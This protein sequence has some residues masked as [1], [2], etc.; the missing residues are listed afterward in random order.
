MEDKTREQY[1]DDSDTE[2]DD[3]PETLTAKYLILKRQLYDLQPKLAQI[4]RKG[5]AQSSKRMTMS[6]QGD[7]PDPQI[8]RL[9]RRLMEIETDIL[10]DRETAQLQ[11]TEASIALAKEASERKR[12]HLSDDTSSVGR[13]PTKNRDAIA[14]QDSSDFTADPD[15]TDSL[16]MLSD[17]FASVD[18]AKSETGQQHS[19]LEEESVLIRDFGNPNGLKP[20]RILEEACKAR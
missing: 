12:L 18:V 5:H 8:A 17:L 6:V 20:R 1:S 14:N 13:I 3:D 10:F 19:N 11:W 2:T 4:N 16:G 9:Q 15:D 7:T